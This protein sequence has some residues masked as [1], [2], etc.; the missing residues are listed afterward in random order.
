MLS[1]QLSTTELADVE[2]ELDS[3][4]TAKYDYVFLL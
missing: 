4:L 3:L 2:A 1:N